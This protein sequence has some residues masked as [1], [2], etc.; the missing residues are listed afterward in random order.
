MVAAVCTKEQTLVLLGWTDGWLVAADLALALKGQGSQATQQI[1][2]T[3][4]IFRD[5]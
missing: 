5:P 4:S 2:A 3:R 1:G